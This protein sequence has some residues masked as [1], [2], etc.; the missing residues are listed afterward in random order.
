VVH[1]SG[2][3]LLSNVH[4]TGL[5]SPTGDDFANNGARG[6]SII[7]GFFTSCLFLSLCILYRHVL[8]MCWWI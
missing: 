4:T 6:Y 1:K 5:E 3:K 8:P 7:V 2:V